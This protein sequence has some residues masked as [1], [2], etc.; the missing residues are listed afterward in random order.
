MSR[1]YSEIPRPQHGFLP[2]VVDV[3]IFTTESPTGI[4]TDE[5]RQSGQMVLLALLHA[6]GMSDAFY[7][8]D[9]PTTPML[10]NSGVSYYHDFDIEWWA[11]TGRAWK[12]QRADCKVLA[13]WRVAE[14]NRLLPKGKGAR[15]HISWRRIEANDPG[16][17]AEGDWVYHVVLIRPA[18]S[19]D[20]S[21]PPMLETP[22]GLTLYPAKQQKWNGDIEEM[23]GWFIEDPSRVL[24]M[25]WEQVYA[26]SNHMPASDQFRGWYP[27]ATGRAWKPTVIDMDAVAQPPGGWISVSPYGAPQ[28]NIHDNPNAPYNR[29][30]PIIEPRMP[31]SMQEVVLDP[32]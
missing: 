17:F 31:A 11:G 13:A 5:E 2:I 9:N 20:I 4:I 6:L 30:A 32:E 8:R 27:D 19:L 24:G 22:A 25:G 18:S 29:P 21:P 1:I 7:I 10:Y 26:G 28:A 12:R 3:P 16:G 23:P 14:L 15:P